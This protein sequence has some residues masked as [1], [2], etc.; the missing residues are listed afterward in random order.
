MKV[1][2][3]TCHEERARINHELVNGKVRKSP[4][5]SLGTWSC[6]ITGKKCKV[7]VERKGNG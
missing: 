7:K 6:P 4:M 2:K 1:Y 5:A 3:C